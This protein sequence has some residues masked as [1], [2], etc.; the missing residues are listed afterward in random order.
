[1]FPPRAILDY[2]AF[3]FGNASTSISTLAY[4]FHNLVLVATYFGVDVLTGSDGA[5]FGGRC[6]D[7]IG[8]KVVTAPSAV[9]H[10]PSVH[11]P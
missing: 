6:G 10:R 2:S 9:H 4:I 7:A 11:A 8:P 5:L 1:M 3:H